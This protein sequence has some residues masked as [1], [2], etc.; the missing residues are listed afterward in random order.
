MEVINVLAAAAAGF[1]WGAA[2]YMTLARPWMKAAG[3]P[4]DDN[5]KPMG[6]GSPLP[7]VLSAVAMILVA[8]MMRHVFHTSGIV[9]LG[10]GLVAGLGIGLFFIAPW[11]MINNAYAGRPFRLTVID[12]GYAVTGCALMGL[13]LSAF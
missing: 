6:N 2:W 7:F 10:G 12:G 8:G 4:M 9:T 1:V 3:I 11:T 13:V 5:G